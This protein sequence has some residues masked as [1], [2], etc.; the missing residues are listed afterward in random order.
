M[1]YIDNFFEI[2]V[3][4]GASDL[5]IGEGQPPKMR[6]HGDVM[7]IREEVV[8]R[9]EAAAMLMRDLRSEKLANF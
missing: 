3:S 4:E 1:P 5:H 8:T 6:K 9:S 7:P 2:L